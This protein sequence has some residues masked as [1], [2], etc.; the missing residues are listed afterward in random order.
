MPHFCPSNPC[1]IC[2]YQPSLKSSREGKL[3]ELLKEVRSFLNMSM[4]LVGADKIRQL[5]KELDQV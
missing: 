5:V 2:N 4:F 3:E 1:P